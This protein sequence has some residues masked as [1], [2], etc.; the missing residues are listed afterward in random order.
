MY[1]IYHH[2]VYEWKVVIQTAVCKMVI[3]YT[4]LALLIPICGISEIDFQMV[5]E[6]YGPFTKLAKWKNQNNLMS[7]RHFH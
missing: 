4:M 7:L 3:N 1:N 5:K 6:K 2:I